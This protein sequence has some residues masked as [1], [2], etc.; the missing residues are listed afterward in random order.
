MITK[1]VTLFGGA[2]KC[3]VPSDWVDASTFR[4][5]P[6]HQEVYMHPTAK[7]E[8]SVIIEILLYDETLADTEAGEYYFR[9]LGNADDASSME[10]FRTS[11][12]RKDVEVFEFVAKRIDTDGI[13][14]KGKL[15]SSS[16]SSPVVVLMSLFRIPQLNSD[17][18]ITCH[19]LTDNRLEIQ[20]VYHLV[21]DSL[22][23]LDRS[24]FF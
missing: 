6:D 15:G 22:C 16:V 13:Q 24:L 17:I 2:A 21:S 9:D 23:F 1:E 11:C 8:Q 3:L 5:V 20:E 19:A 7:G 4:D 10:I 12:E 14:V 18:L